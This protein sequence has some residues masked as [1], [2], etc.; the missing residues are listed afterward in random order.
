MSSAKCHFADDICSPSSFLHSDYCI[1]MVSILS[2]LQTERL[3]EIYGEGVSSLSPSAFSTTG[4]SHDDVIKRK[5]FPR[6]W[7]FVQGIHQSPVKSPHKGQW[8][9][10][11]MFS[12]IC[13]WINGLVN[14]RKAGDLRY[15]RTHYDVIVMRNRTAEPS[16]TQHVLHMTHVQ[17]YAKDYILLQ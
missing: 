9:G 5:H 2:Q 12:L 17:I 4:I 15:Y 14:N 6:Y 10:A 1:L 7:P 16:D 13:V 11:L 8:R 3:M